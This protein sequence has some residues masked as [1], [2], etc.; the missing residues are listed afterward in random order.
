MRQDHTLGAPLPAINGDLTID[1]QGHTISGD[2]RFRIF[3]IEGGTVILKRMTLIQGSKAAGNGGAI[4]TRNHA[5]FT[6]FKLTFRDNRA[7]WGGAIA[8]E[9]F[10]VLRV[11]D[12]EFYDNAA[13]HRGGAVYAEGRCARLDGN[14][15]RR[16]TAP[17]TR[18]IDGAQ[19]HLDGRLMPCGGRE[20]NY[21]S[22]T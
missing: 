22:D 13:A 16:N 6:S 2:N 17:L 14:T 1:G 8:S 19:S 21:F 7:L 4:V 5:D 9:D 11:Y 12:S 10:S 3:D 15:F 18:Y 20:F